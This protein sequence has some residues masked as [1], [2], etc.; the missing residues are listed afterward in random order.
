MYTISHSSISSSSAITGAKYIQ[1]VPLQPNV[2]FTPTGAPFD[3]K[4]SHSLDRSHTLLANDMEL[5]LI[6]I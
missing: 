4:M 2:V 3:Q 6:H 5:S 1:I